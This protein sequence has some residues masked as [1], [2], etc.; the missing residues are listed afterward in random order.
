MGTKRM[1][2]AGWPSRALRLLA[3]RPL[4]V[5]TLV[6]VS[7]A[8]GSWLGA[9]YESPP[10][11]P[12]P[13]GLSLALILAVNLPLICR[14]KAPI[15]VL[16]VSCSCAIVYH[17]LGYHYGVNNI[18]PPLA[19]YSVAAR[20]PP[21]VS[22]ASA[23][24]VLA[25]WTHAGMMQ[26]LVAP[27]AAAGTAILITVS[28][29]SLGTAVR[30]LTE[31]NRRLADLAVRLELEQESR[32]RRAA[33]EE[34]VKIARELHDVVAH[35]VALISMQAGLGRYVFTTDPAT[36]H[37]TLETISDASREAMTEMRRMLSILRT[38]QDGGD[39][40]S[41]DF[42]PGLDRLEQLV[43]RL[44]SSGVPV[45][46]RFA[47]T[48]RPLNPGLELCAY[49]VVQESLTNVLKHAPGARTEVVVTYGD[50]ALGI[51]V[52]NE[53]GD[54]PAAARSGGQGLIGMTERV[55]LYGGTIVAGPRPS[56]GFEVEVGL[57]FAPTEQP[58]LGHG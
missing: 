15:T 23:M 55:K 46:F 39:D 57:P 22:A 24:L 43:R 12:P 18:G 32:A 28:V 14:R 7:L 34:R 52:T 3:A 2:F 51:R 38:D 10:G 40:E 25:E 45:R 6:A 54:P 37:A 53:P 27:W 16:V 49:R 8:A 9:M 5:D 41:R 30:S 11:A 4:I 26:P 31:R 47:G 1:A 19:L 56:G 48:R 21:A 17:L 50:S 35:H 42:T 29:L 13:D 58:A 20:R 44:D 36:A 33:T